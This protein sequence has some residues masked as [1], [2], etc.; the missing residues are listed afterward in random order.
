MRRFLIFTILLVFAAGFAFSADFGLLADQKIEAEKELFTYTL[1]FTPWFSWNNGNGV[2]LFLSGLF[3]LQYINDNGNSGWLEPGL[4]PEL[5]RF[6]LSYRINQGM[7]LEAGRFG[8]A[9]VLDIA[10]SGFFDGL[11]FDFDAPIGSVSAG[12]FYTGLQYKETA[13]IVMT[14]NDAANFAKPWDFDSIGDY[15]ASRRAFITLCWNVPLGETNTLSAEALAQFDLNDSDDKLHS[16]YGA[17]QMEFYPVNKMRITLGGLFETMQNSD[18]DFG[19][20]FGALAKV[21]MN[22]PTSVNDTFGVTVKF[23]SGASGDAFTAFMPIS[24]IP[25]GSIFAGTIAG[26]ALAEV[27]YIARLIDPL[28][29]ECAFRYYIK[30]YDDDA[31]DGSLYGGELWASFKWQPLDDIRVTLG[32]GAFFPGMGNIYPDDAGVM[33]KITAGLTVS[34]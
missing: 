33:W 16:Q 27:G 14:G 3:S 20:A 24:S 17:L 13:K 5:S 2:S 34:F 23:T 10:A 22:L 4:V 9:D 7:S 1:G 32:A 26:L 8:Y 11:R 15:Y 25:Q 21:K 6:A 18:G 12:A 29:A 30:T 28:L 31:I 19:A